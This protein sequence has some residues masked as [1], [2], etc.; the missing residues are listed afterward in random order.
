MP[1]IRNGDSIWNILPND[2][3]VA[4][5]LPMNLSLALLDLVQT[6]EEQHGIGF[7]GQ[8]HG[9]GLAGVV[10]AA[11][12]VKAG[13]KAH[14]LQAALG[15]LLQHR[16]HL[17]G[18]DGAGARALIPGRLGEITHDSH[19]LARFQRKQTALVLEYLCTEL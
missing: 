7:P 12:T 13:G 8:R 19:P 9:L 2:L 16:I 3:T 11:L 10:R 6:Q 15:Q 17:D 1:P 14:A 5:Q 4:G 18:V